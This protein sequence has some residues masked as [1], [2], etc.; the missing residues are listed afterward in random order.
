[1]QAASDFSTLPVDLTCDRLAVG[2]KWIKDGRRSDRLRPVDKRTKIFP[3]HVGIACGAPRR[4]GPE[5]AVQRVRPSL[6]QLLAP[7]TA[8]PAYIRGRRTEVLALNPL[9]AFLLADFPAKPAPERSLIRWTFLGAEARIRYVDWE[10][11]ASSMVGILRLDAG[12]HP[13]DLLLLQ[14]VSELA[15]HSEEFRTWWADHRVVEHSDG[16]KRL[17]HPPGGHLDIRYE[18]LEVTGEPA[19]TLRIYI[20]EPGSESKLRTLAGW[21]YGDRTARDHAETPTSPSDQQEPRPNADNAE[22]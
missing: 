13:D 14:F 1:M 9:A 11:I 5:A 4:T 22:H 12:R 8:H 3:A 20:A 21:V 16:I 2:E 18:A 10:K 17:N 7:F 6:H 15:V 19:Q